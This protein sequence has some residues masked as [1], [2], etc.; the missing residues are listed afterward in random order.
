MKRRQ[1]KFQSIVG[2]S[3]NLGWAEREL[4][5]QN[6]TSRLPDRWKLI[7]WDLIDAL[8][9]RTPRLLS[10]SLDFLSIPSSLSAPPATQSSLL[11]RSAATSSLATTG[12][13]YPHHIHR[14]LSPAQGRRAAGGFLHPGHQSAPGRAST[15]VELG[16]VAAYYAATYRFISI[17][18]YAA[19]KEE[20][21]SSRWCAA[22]RASSGP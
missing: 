1:T 4:L 12:M 2:D 7:L 14:S 13:S 19:H 17:S 18:L 9:S 16:A 15:V 20:L 3:K 10:Q 6:E 5:A 8:F 22:S 11:A 21:A